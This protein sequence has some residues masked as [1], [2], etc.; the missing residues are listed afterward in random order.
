MVSGSRAPVPRKAH[1]GGPG[2][3]AQG[4]ALPATGGVLLGRDYHYEVVRPG[5]GLYGGRPFEAA[6]PVVTLSLPVIQVRTV[7]PDEAVGYGWVWG[8]TKPTRIATVAAG[9]ADGIHRALS[10]RA[11]L[12]SGKTACP[13]VGRVSMD[14]LTIDVS[15]LDH[16]PET[17]DLVNADHG[18]DTLADVAG[19][20][21]Y[22]LFT[23]LGRRYG[24]SYTG[25]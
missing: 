7:E 14:L 13:L 12:W 22:E 10:N 9:Y 5:I 24:R 25:G 15:A 23:S 3:A 1:G 11:L 19:T 6:A 21:G 18:L 20:I 17:L 2:G 16:D 8:A 4:P